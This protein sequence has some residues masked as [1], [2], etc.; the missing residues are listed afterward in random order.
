[1]SA[2]PA[3]NRALGTVD[4][5]KRFNIDLEMELARLHGHVNRKRVE[6]L[7]ALEAIG[8][9]QSI[10]ASRRLKVVLEQLDIVSGRVKESEEKATSKESTA[11]ERAGVT[12]FY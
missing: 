7:A 11:R 2:A 10:V 5:A 6:L 4:Y 9:E 12:V 1:M 8:T 3:G